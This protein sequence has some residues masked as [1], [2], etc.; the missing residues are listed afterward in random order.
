MEDIIID[1]SSWPFFETVHPSHIHRKTHTKTEEGNTKTV[2]AYGYHII[3][4]CFINLQSFLN[5]EK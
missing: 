5:E 3:K 2:L 4:F 1:H